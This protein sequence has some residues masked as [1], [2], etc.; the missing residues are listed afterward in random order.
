MLLLLL[1]VSILVFVILEY[2]K[3]KDQKG[4]SSLSQYPVVYGILILFGSIVGAGFIYKA[5]DSM[6]SSK[7]NVTRFRP[8]G[9]D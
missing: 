2:K 5:I 8:R 4:G 9:G 3:P 7:V 1:S 6:K